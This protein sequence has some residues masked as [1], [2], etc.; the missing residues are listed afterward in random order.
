M[1]YEMY[2]LIY[3]KII[4]MSAVYNFCAGPA[5]LPVDVMK[6]AQT[7]FINW[8]NTGCSVME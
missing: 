8:N 2:P 4:P 1:F 7:E 6:K 5:M 3:R